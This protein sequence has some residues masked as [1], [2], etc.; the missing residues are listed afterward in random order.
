MEHKSDIKK[1][2][3]F[4]TAGRFVCNLYNTDLSLVEWAMFPI[5]VPNARYVVVTF[6]DVY[7]KIGSVCTMQLQRDEIPERIVSDGYDLGDGEYELCVHGF[8]FEPMVIKGTVGSLIE[9]VKRFGGMGCSVY[10]AR[11]G[12]ELMYEAGT[13]KVVAHV[14]KIVG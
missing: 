11:T 7:D 9:I 6:E 13:S 4:D 8:V 1:F 3:I 12:N 2:S 10:C 14:F 5:V